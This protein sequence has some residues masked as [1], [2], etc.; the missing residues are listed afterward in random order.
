M[1]PLESSFW[2]RIHQQYQLH[3]EAASMR[4]TSSIMRASLQPRSFRRLLLCLLR[5]RVSIVSD[6]GIPS[7]HH[8]HFIQRSSWVA[9]QVAQLVLAVLSG[10]VAW[11]CALPA[12]T[13]RQ[14]IV[15]AGMALYQYAY[16]LGL[17]AVGW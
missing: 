14:C 6:V 3:I 10:L 5:R 4:H 9:V 11:L 7:T 2:S 1:T 15:G 12:H 13:T 17:E 16:W 8:T